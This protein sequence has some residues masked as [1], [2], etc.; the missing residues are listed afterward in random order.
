[1]TTEEFNYNNMPIELKNE[2]VFIKMW[3]LLDLIFC[4]DC[5]TIALMMFLI[6]VYE[7]NNI[8]EIAYFCPP[9]N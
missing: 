5:K 1:M 9:F 3:Y 8:K 4:I 6:F 7:R 2:Y